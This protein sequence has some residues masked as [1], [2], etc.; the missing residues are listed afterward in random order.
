VTELSFSWKNINPYGMV[1]FSVVPHE[2]F[3]LLK[4]LL[5]YLDIYQLPLFICR[6]CSNLDYST[7]ESLPGVVYW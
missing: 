7:P 1:P 5:Y 2:L 4:I 6:Y 3:V